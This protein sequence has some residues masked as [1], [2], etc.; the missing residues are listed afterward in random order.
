MSESSLSRFVDA[1]G[2]GEFESA[3][4]EM[5]AGR[6]RSHWIWYIFPQ[7]SGLGM[8]HMSQTYAIRDRDEAVAYLHHP[9]LSARLLEIAAA[10]AEQLG[11]GVALGSLMGSSIDANKLVSSMTLFAEV[12]QTLPA[13]QGSASATALARTADAILAAAEAQGYSR[14]A[15]TL[16]QLGT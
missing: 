15:F 12:G 8:S 13:G 10:V 5:K 9:L 6:K 1:Q 3:L 14:C 4:A 11:T 7:L 2:G 16:R